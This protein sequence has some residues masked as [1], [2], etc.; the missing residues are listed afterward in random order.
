MIPIPHHFVLR[1][2]MMWRSTGRPASTESPTRSSFTPLLMPSP[3][4]TWNRMPIRPKGWP[5]AGNLLEVIWLELADDLNLV[6]HAMPLRPA[7]N[8]LLPQ[9]PKDMP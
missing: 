7:F 3:S 9:S 5:S 8:H 4:S 6:I 1:Y 2:A